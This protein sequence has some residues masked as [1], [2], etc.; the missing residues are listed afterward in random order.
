MLVRNFKEQGAGDQ[1]LMFGYAVN[2][3]PNQMPLMI[4][5]SHKLSHRLT[6]VRKNGIMPELRPDG[7]T[8]V[9]A[10][11]VDGRLKELTPS[12]FLLSTQMHCPWEI[13]R[14]E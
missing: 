11:Y 1:G 10:E 7:K 5:L 2:E 3:T 9:S 12:S 4:D 13:S 14:K 8:Q 6:E